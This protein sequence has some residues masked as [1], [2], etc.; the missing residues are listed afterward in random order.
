MI[1]PREAGFDLLSKWFNEH[2]PLTVLLVTANSSL[3]VKVTGFVN[4][5]SQNVIISDGTHE[6]TIIP[7]NHVIFTADA[8]R[9]FSYLENKDLGVSQV[10]REYVSKNDH[11]GN[12]SVELVD[13]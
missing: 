7:R 4:G 9:S 11:A 10:E 3:A 8:I 2:T 1:T 5:I 6:R 12:L 13:G